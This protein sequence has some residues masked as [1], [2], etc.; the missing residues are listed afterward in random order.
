MLKAQTKQ[1]IYLIYSA[2]WWDGGQF[3]EQIKWYIKICRLFSL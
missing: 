1:N 2:A 3:S